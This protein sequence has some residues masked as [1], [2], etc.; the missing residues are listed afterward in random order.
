MEVLQSLANLGVDVG[1]KILLAVLILIVGRIII[2]Y[3]IKGLSKIKKFDE[4]DPTVHRF[5]TNAVKF[6]LNAILVISI[7][8]VLGVPMASIIAVLASAGMAVGLALQ[9]SLSNM[10]GGI[11]LLIFRPFNVDD[12]VSSAIFKASRVCTIPSCSPSTTVPSSCPT[13]LS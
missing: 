11:M 1:G 8:T 7:I 13:G 5:F 9:G 3:L 10:A 4:L 2:K 6:V 12:Y